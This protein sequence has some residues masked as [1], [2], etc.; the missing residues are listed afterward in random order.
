[1]LKFKFTVPKIERLKLD[2]GRLEEAVDRGA[3]NH[4][5]R[6]GLGPG[7]NMKGALVAATSEATADAKVQLRQSRTQAEWFGVAVT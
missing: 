5:R 4:M 1:M 2:I 6:K 7:Q 3:R